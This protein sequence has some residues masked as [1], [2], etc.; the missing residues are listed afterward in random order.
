MAPAGT[1]EGAHPTC[2]LGPPR[3]HA[4][5]S[6]LTAG[7]AA[8]ATVAV[9]AAPQSA[10]TTETSP[11]GFGAGTTGGGSASAVTVSTLSSF[12]TAVTGNSAKVVKARTPAI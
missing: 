9:L 12:R 1:S 5:R 2:V 6:A 11:I 4:Q 3:T 8:L 7:A 10:G